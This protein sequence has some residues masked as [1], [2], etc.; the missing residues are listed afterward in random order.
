MLPV[1]L[2]LL[3]MGTFP[4]TRSGAAC[5]EWLGPPRDAV[6]PISTAKSAPMVGLRALREPHEGIFHPH[7]RLQPQAPHYVGASERA[8]YDVQYG[9]LGRVGKLTLSSAAPTV[10]ADGQTVLTL[11]AEGAGAVLGLG[12]FQRTIDSEFDLHRRTSRRWRSTRRSV[13]LA[14]DETVSDSVVH[15]AGDSLLIE[16]RKAA[17]AAPSEQ[18]VLS[19]A[20]VTSDPLGLIWRLRAQPPAPGQRVLLQMLDGMAL[21][22][23]EVRAPPGGPVPV[24]S[25]VRL[26]NELDAELTPILYNGQRDPA[27]PERRFRL[28]LTPDENRTPLRL[29]MPMGLADAV[30]VLEE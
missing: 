11:R 21:W 17:S 4:A 27:R 7:A 13:G 2:S 26:G 16:R 6:A 12:R 5:D 18:Q 28:W 1:A 22:R 23:V 29:E 20:G 24:P 14:S 8:T 10:T 25:S 3:V 30:I 9:V 15:Q 19:P